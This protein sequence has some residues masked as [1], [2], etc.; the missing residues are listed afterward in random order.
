MR[1]LVFCIGMVATGC[2]GTTTG[3]ALAGGL[4]ARPAAPGGSVT[5]GGVGCACAISAGTDVTAV[6]IS[7]VA[8]IRLV[9]RANIVASIVTV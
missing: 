8:T 2:G 1:W 4:I 9:F 5:T 6:L 7:S 3:G